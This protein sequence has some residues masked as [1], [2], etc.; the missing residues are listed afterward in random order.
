MVQGDLGGSS[1]PF[2]FDGGGTAPSHKVPEG[3]SFIGRS[4]MMG[5]DETCFCLFWFMLGKLV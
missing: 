5:E 3:Y 2:A 1:T 4:A